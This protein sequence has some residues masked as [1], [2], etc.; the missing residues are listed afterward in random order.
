M[1][2]QTHLLDGNPRNKRFEEICRMNQN[3]L[4]KHMKKKWNMIEYP[5]VI[6]HKGTVPI[7]LTAHMD[8]VHKEL[9]ADIQYINGT[10]TSPQGIGGDDRCGI[11]IIEK[12][13]EAGIDCSVLLCEDEE[14]GSVGAYK[15]IETP[16]AEALIGTFKFI[17]ELDRMNSND[18]VFYEGN[19]KEFEQF[20][21]KEF[22]KKNWG[23]WSDICVLAPFF[24]CA[25]VNLSCGYYKAHTTSEYVRLPEVYKVISEVKK[26]IARA[27]GVEAFKWVAKP[28]ANYGLYNYDDY[29]SDYY[30]GYYSKYVLWAQITPITVSGKT[31]KYVSAEGY[32]KN[33]CYANLFLNHP[34]LSYDMIETE[35]WE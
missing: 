34:W 9:C 33:E 29:Y 3:T 26:L 14:V 31:Y 15:F 20:V 5:G 25:A 35:Y 12:I 17:I 24:D 7:L 27:E 18:A 23:S 4:R 16:E 21:T 11:Y 22:F 8:T 6:Y 19:N 32:S 10:V 1:Q 13:L 30:S 2:K 28:K